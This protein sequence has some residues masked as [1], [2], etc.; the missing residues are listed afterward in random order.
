M[1]ALCIRWPKYW[2]FSF[3]ISPSNEYLGLKLIQTYYFI[4]ININIITIIDILFIRCCSVARIDQFSYI[5]SN[6]QTTLWSV[7]YDPC[8][9]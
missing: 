9:M 1:T 7:Y 2:S 5:I 8:F 4:I 6:P 3:S